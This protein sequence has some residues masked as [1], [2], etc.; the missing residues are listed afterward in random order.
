[1]LYVCCNALD[2]VEVSRL[3]SLAKRSV[4]EGPI[5]VRRLVAVNG[6]EI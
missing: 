1:M 2:L 4:I 3:F 5:L 6:L